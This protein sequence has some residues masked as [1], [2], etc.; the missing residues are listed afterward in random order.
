MNRTEAREYMMQTIFQMEASHDFDVNQ[1]HT[2]MRET[3]PAGQKEYCDDLFSLICNKR[4]IIDQVIDQ[5]S[6]GWTNQR[7]PKTD[8]AILRVAACELLFMPTIPAAVSI[9]EAVELAKKYGTDESSG[10]INGI[11]GKIHKDGQKHE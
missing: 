10:Y 5:F 2:Y 1:K 3:I 4:E 6:I 11:L 7:M 8:L 9:N